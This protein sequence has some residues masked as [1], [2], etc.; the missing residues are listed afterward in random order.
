MIIYEFLCI[1]HLGTERF[2]QPGS[3][4]RDCDC[5]TFNLQ[6]DYMLV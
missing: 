1:L 4:L 5:N 3:D 2:I 6:I